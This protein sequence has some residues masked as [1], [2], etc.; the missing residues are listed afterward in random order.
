MRGFYLCVICEHFHPVEWDGDCRDDNNRY[1][2]DELDEKYGSD[3]WV[4]VPMPTT[5]K[6]K[7][8]KGF[9]F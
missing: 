3:G 8:G 2:T 9:N 6:A 7:H 4:E 1:T 5:G